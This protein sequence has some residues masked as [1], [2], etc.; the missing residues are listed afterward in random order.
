MWDQ[1]NPLKSAILLAVIPNVETLVLQNIFFL[2]KNN[3]LHDVLY[4]VTL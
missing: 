2:G 3:D 1:F 4:T